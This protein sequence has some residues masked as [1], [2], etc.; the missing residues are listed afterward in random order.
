MTMLKELKVKKFTYQKVLSIII[1]SLSIKNFY[2][3]PNDSD[4]KR[5][6]EIKKC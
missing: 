1:M 6:E 2:D 3:Q 5:Y 4:I